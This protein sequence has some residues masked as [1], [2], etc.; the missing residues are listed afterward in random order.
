M[1]RLMKIERKEVKVD[2][3]ENANVG[4]KPA[5]PRKINEKTQTKTLTGNQKIKPEIK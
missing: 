3:V 2:S 5:R 4:A 1:A